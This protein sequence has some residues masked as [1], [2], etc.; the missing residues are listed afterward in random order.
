MTHRIAFLAPAGIAC[1]AVLSWSAWLLVTGPLAHLMHSSSDAIFGAFTIV[2]ICVSIIAGVLVGAWNLVPKGTELHPR[3]HH[4]G[5]HWPL[6][7]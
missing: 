6:H 1:L 5:H 2:L 3:P 7:H 4:F